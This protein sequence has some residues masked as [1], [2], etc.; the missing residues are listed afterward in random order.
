MVET[1][2]TQK[3]GKGLDDEIKG[4]PFCLVEFTEADKTNN[5]ILCE[6]GKTFKVIRYS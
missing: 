2:P 1:E 6:C 5:K 4:C 3:E